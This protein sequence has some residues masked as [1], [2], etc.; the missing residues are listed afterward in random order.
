M[1]KAPLLCWD[2]YSAMVRVKQIPSPKEKDLLMLQNLKQQY[3]WSTD[4]GMLEKDYDALVLT[5]H[6]RSIIWVSPGFQKMT[7]YPAY[8]AVGKKP[9]FLQ[10]EHTSKLAL[11]EI[12][13]YLKTNQPFKSQLLNYKIDQSPYLCEIEIFP[14]KNHN[15]EVTHFLALEKE[16]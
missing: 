10:G 7:G 15:E 11:I 9:S 12:S 5:D 13:N 2:I 14:L 4:I 1:K 3:Q 6:A 16:L 8:F